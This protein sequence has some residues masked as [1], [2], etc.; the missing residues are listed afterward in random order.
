MAKHRIEITADTSQAEK[1]LRTLKKDV[2][3]VGKSA[4]KKVELGMSWGK[5]A[6]GGLV[7]GVTQNVLGN[8]L[9]QTA[10][11]IVSTIN[12]LAGFIPVLRDMTEFRSA[13]QLAS[14]SLEL[15]SKGLEMAKHPEDEVF[16]RTNNAEQ[17]Q[18]RAAR[19]GSSM[20]EQFLSEQQWSRAFGQESAQRFLESAAKAVADAEADM[21]GKAAD[22]L[23]SL[24]LTHN[25][26][27]DS[28]GNAIHDLNKLAETV[29]RAAVS[30]L[31]E[32]PNNRATEDSI[33]ALFG[34]KGATLIRQAL[35]NGRIEA[36]DDVRDMAMTALEE[37][38]KRY[39]EATG[40]TGSIEDLWN[41]IAS[42][43]DKFAQNAAVKAI[44]QALVNPDF[45]DKAVKDQRDFSEQEKSLLDLI[46][47]NKYGLTWRQR[48]GES[49][50][51]YQ[52]RLLDSG[53]K[54]N[55]GEDEQAWEQRMRDQDNAELQES[56]KE[57]LGVD[58][59]N[60]D[61]IGD[62]LKTGFDQVVEAITG[63]SEASDKIAEIA[64]DIF[65]GL[66]T[67]LGHLGV[68]DEL[69]NSYGKAVDAYNE[70]LAAKEAIEYYM[71]LG[72]RRDE[73]DRDGE[74]KDFARKLSEVNPELL[75]KGIERQLNDNNGKR[76]DR[77]YYL[78]EHGDKTEV[79]MS[80]DARAQ[81][82]AAITAANADGVR[83]NDEIL[84][85]LR[86]TYDLQLKQADKQNSPASGGGGNAA[87]FQ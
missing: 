49:D 14:N 46:F 74:L 12:A 57:F 33:N 41:E 62:E 1:K 82:Q 63:V 58:K 44:Q 81:I 56:L 39:R 43:N 51:D 32:D 79:K 22:N 31:Q 16:K 84:N 2:V 47:Q 73:I 35:G 3:D 61:A 54:R 83:T 86:L 11:S 87:T 71:G 66:V 85:I 52:K 6:F 9:A 36:F 21:G 69:K 75:L 29:L 30:K 4:A 24:G 18:H 40:R 72:Y 50:A 64:L 28:E 37:E 55:D 77:G 10:G 13:L 45:V 78:D 59:M 70:R 25:S 60:F 27:L 7:S 53:R 42:N 20:V 48:D 23:A 80:P 8:G 19:N 5:A 76:Q 17:L 15:F 68:G 26:F 38:F 34:P 67:F 65:G